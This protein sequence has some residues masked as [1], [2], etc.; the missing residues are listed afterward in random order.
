MHAVASVRRPVITTV[1]SQSWNTL[2]V[3]T[4]VSRYE[5]RRGKQLGSDF[6][7]ADA[8]HTRS[9]V[10]VTGTVLASL[11]LVRFGLPRLDAILSILIAG[12]IGYI[13]YGVFMRTFPVLVDA[14]AVSEGH[15]QRVVQSVPGVKSAHAVRSRRAGAVVF[16]DM[17]LLVEP[18]DTEATHAL[19]E[20][21]EA[22]LEHE[23]GR[24]SATI[25]VETAR[26]CG[27]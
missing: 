6:L 14:S 10:L 11:V 15:L 20:A 19:T 8:A 7:M 17:H 3:N 12:F 9:D 21:V 4:L 13:G 16:I 2:L 26:D 1:P 27:F 5:A 25:H 22:A 23:F 18:G 24:T